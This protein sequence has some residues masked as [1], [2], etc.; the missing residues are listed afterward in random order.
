M[1]V[2][3]GFAGA[4]NDVVAKKIK[5]RNSNDSLE[6]YERALTP[7][8]SPGSHESEDNGLIE[9]GFCGPREFQPCS[10][11]PLHLPPWLR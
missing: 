10:P 6:Q 5:G 9:N 4:L 7:M 1:I 2:A 11:R 8:F 3:D